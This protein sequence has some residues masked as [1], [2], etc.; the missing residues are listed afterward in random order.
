MGEDLGCRVV[1][2]LGA[3]LDA[4]AQE[5]FLRVSSSAVTRVAHAKAVNTDRLASASA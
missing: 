2:L 1:R 5:D 3:L 4:P